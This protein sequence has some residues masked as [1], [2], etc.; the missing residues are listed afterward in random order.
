[1]HQLRN[2]GRQRQGSL[3]AGGPQREGLRLEWLATGLGGFP[4]GGVDG[5][6]LQSE[7]L[8][9]AIVALIQLR[10]LDD[11]RLGHVDDDA[12]FASEMLSFSKKG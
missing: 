7:V 12:K 8:T 6:N 3:N 9:V 10:A 1:M 2:V 4:C 5:H 11:D